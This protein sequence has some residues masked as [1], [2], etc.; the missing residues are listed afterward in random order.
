[1]VVAAH[2]VSF[3]SAGTRAITGP[4]ATI[5]ALGNRVAAAVPTILSLLTGIV[6]PDGCP[7]SAPVVRSHR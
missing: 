2:A 1:V 4:E 7:A 6:V 3:R 5:S